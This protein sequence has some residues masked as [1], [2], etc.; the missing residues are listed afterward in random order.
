MP[1]LATQCA[2]LPGYVE[3][4]FER[5]LKCGRLEGGFLR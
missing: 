2:P 5:Y 1:H 4:E 3:R